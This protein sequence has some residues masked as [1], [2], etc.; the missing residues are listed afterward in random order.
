MVLPKFL[1]L[2]NR[3]ATKNIKKK[4]IKYLIFPNLFKKSIFKTMR[5]NNQQEVI[6]YNHTG[7]EVLLKSNSTVLPI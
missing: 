3:S 1:L 2:V 6:D 4:T 5:V 7:K